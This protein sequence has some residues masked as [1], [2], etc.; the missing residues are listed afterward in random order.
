ML[1]LVSA[2]SGQELFPET[3]PGKKLMRGLG[4]RLEGNNRPGDME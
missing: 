4:R 2:N 1:N 3:T